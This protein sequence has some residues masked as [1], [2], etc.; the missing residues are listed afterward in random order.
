MQYPNCKDHNHS[1]ELC[2]TKES[3]WVQLVSGERD[4]P[5]ELYKDVSLAWWRACKSKVPL[6]DEEVWVAWFGMTVFDDLLQSH[7]MADA[8][9]PITRQGAALVGILGELDGVVLITDGLI[10]QRFRS[11]E[12]GELNV[13]AVPEAWLEK[14]NSD[15]APFILPTLM[16]KAPSLRMIRDPNLK[17]FDVE[18]H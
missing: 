4:I 2:A 12:D 17:S 7:N 10:E 13:M 18:I 3:C 14:L 15:T 11:L 8:F 5:T 9:N 6:G 1:Y 16:N